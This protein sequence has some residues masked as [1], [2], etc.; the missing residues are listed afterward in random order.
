MAGDTLDVP[1][2]PE[3]RNAPRNPWLGL[4]ADLLTKIQEIARGMQGSEIMGGRLLGHGLDYLLGQG[5]QRL[6]EAASGFPPVTGTGETLAPKP[7]LLD[8]TNLMPVSPTAGIAKAVGA[9]KGIVSAKAALPGALSAIFVPAKPDKVIKAEFQKKLGLSPSQIWQQTGA[10]EV[11][12]GTGW[13]EEIRPGATK[14]LPGLDFEGALPLN[15][16]RDTT[17]LA[18]YDPKLAT[19]PVE[20]KMSPSAEST[21]SSH[22]PT[23][24]EVDYGTTAGLHG[25]AEHELQHF[26]AADVPG[27][28]TGANAGA[29]MDLAEHS[30]NDPAIQVPLQK[31]LAGWNNLQN[32]TPAQMYY[33]DA[34]NQQVAWAAQPGPS[35]APFRRFMGHT[36]YAHSAGEGLARGADERF[37]FNSAAATATL[38]RNP[39]AWWNNAP[40]QHASVGAA[41]PPEAL[42]DIPVVPVRSIR[43]A[44]GPVSQVKPP[45]PLFLDKEGNPHG[46]PSGLDSH[47]NYLNRVLGVD[48]SPEEAF[49]AGLFYVDS[50]GKQPLIITGKA[51]ASREEATALAQQYAN[52]TSQ[53]VEVAYDAERFTLQP[54]ESGGK[55]Q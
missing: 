45:H 51:Q 3:L 36:I 30:W 50:G 13:V 11:F 23:H 8:L 12:P 29:W 20:L 18:K 33:R 19:L 42:V 14:P 54:T 15:Q 31:I 47:G 5:P 4:P 40:P 2:G 16:L 46:T 7:G 35:N 43:L 27:W 28:S 48:N 44:G 6:D 52:K 10:T 1:L 21:G 41:I 9:V 26:V 49:K 53:P 34:I 32:P 17:E 38:P 37:F 39:V 55:S 22:H 25:S 24:I